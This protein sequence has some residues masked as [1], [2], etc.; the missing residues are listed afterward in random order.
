MNKTF[1]NED[2]I[3]VEQVINSWISVLNQHNSKQQ[4]NE[5]RDIRNILVSHIP[6]NQLSLKKHPKKEIML[7][8]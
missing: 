5:K 8:F 1:L 2:C 6:Y 7:F 4:E 3:E